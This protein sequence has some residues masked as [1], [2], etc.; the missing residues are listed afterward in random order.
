MSGVL[1]GLIAA[2]PTPITSSFESIATLS[3]SGVQTVT[4]SSI[5]QTYKHLQLRAIFKSSDTFSNDV[6]FNNDTGA[7]YD[8][9]NLRGSG[10][11]A[12]AGRN[13]SSSQAGMILTNG[14]GSY[15]GVGIIDF[16]DY[17]LT[18][19]FKTVRTLSGLNTN[20]AVTEEIRLTSSLWEN[21]SAISSI[22]ISNNGAVN[23]D[24]GTSFALYG[25]KG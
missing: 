7:N 18:N 3:G 17:S 11:A 25:I 5:P 24:S 15:Y 12:S 22:K 8:Y 1:G 19:K 16:I 23:W 10:T 4:F 14:T 2:F 20:G 21:T 9:N 13:A 6:W